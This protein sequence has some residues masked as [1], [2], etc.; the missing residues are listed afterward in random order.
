MTHTLRLDV[1]EALEERSYRTIQ[2]LAL[3]L[4]SGTPATQAQVR[5]VLFAEPETFYQMEDW[6]DLAIFH[7]FEGQTFHGRGRGGFDERKFLGRVLAE[8]LRTKGMPVELKTLAEKYLLKIG[9]RIGLQKSQFPSGSTEIVRRVR[10]FLDGNPNYHLLHDECIEC[11]WTTPEWPEVAEPA[12]VIA[13]AYRLPDDFLDRAAI[14]LEKRGA[15]AVRLLDILKALLGIDANHADF[16]AA[17]AQANAAL[18]AD[19][20]TFAQVQEQAWMLANYLPASIED[21]PARVAIPRWRNPQEEQLIAELY[22]LPLDALAEAASFAGDDARE[23]EPAQFDENYFGPLRL[24][25]PYHWRQ[26]G[27]LK[28]NANERRLFPDRPARVHLLFTDQTGE[29]FPVWLNNDTGYLHGLKEWYASYLVPAGGVFYIE[30]APGSHYNFK[31]RVKEAASR[32]FDGKQYFCEVDSDTYIEE[33][34]L[35][36]L[37]TLRAKVETAAATIKDVM[38][39]LFESG[40]PD[41]ALHYKQVWAQVHVIRPTTRRTVAAILSAFPCFYQDDPGSGCWRYVPGLR[42]APPKYQTRRVPKP[43]AAVKLAPVEARPARYWLAPVLAAS[44]DKL[45]RPAGSGEGVFLAPWHGRSRVGRG[46]G[47]AFFDTGTERVIAAVEALRQPILDAATGRRELTVKPALDAFN[48]IP[49]ANLA[50]ALSVPKPDPDGFPVEITPEDWKLLLERLRPL[51]VQKTIEPTL[52]ELVKKALPRPEGPDVVEIIPHTFGPNPTIGAFIA[53]YGRPYDPKEPYE[54]SAFATPVKAGKNTAIY[55]AHSYHTKVPPQ[56]IE[57]Y[58]EHY[59]RPGDIVLDPFCGSGMTGVASL[60]LG[61][62]VI[63]NDLSPAATHIAYNYCT[64]VDV[65]ALKREFERIKA[66]V[67]E[68]FDWLYGT[69]CNRCGG[70]AT[71]Q[72]T[73][74]SDVLECSKCGKEIILWKAAVDLDAGRV[75]EEFSCPNCGTKQTKRDTRWVRSDAVLTAYECSQCRPTRHEHTI[76]EA[77]GKRVDEIDLAAISYWYPTAP[78]DDSW[79]MW[80]GVHRDQGI[81]DVSRFYTKRNLWALARLWHEFGQ[82]ADVRIS[83][84]LRFVFTS[85]LVRAARM[86]RYNL[87][88]AGNAPVSGTLYVPSL[89]VE[90]NIL[91]LM[92]RKFDDVF[93]GLSAADWSSGTQAL[94][95]TGSATTLPKEMSNCVDYVFTDPPFGSNIFYADCNFIWEAW[96]SHGFTDQ[97]KEAVVHVKHRNKNTLPEYTQLMIDSFREMYRVLKP[98]RWA[99]VV[100]HNS[101]DRIWQAIQQAAEVAGFDLA[102]AMVFDKEQR[103]FKGI[104]GEK[105]LEKV[106]NFDIVLNLH[107]RGEAQPAAQPEAQTRIEELIAA[108][109][110]KHL[111]SSPAPDYRTGQYLH[112]LAIRTLLN[113]KISV[114]LTWNQLEG[115]L[116]REFRHVNCHWYLPREAVTATGHGFLVRSETAAVA[117]LE[118]ILAAD[119]QTAADL[120]PQWQIA[121]LGAGSRI[122]ATLDEL[123]RDNFWPDET[124]GAWTV[125]TPAQREL[126]RKR[127]PRPQQ[128]SLGLEV[129]GEQMGLG[130]R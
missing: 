113:E 126:L 65:A 31:V 47:L 91:K 78:F 101:D 89:S 107:K 102:N 23:S 61:R 71:I 117:W 3:H 12:P 52:E 32:T 16:S 75:S 11:V 62:R 10:R 73:I 90:N 115:I 85:A 48:P 95:T 79:E 20:E 92:D 124:T 13:P 59:T 97:R 100:F 112:S 123:L 27:V 110:Q 64:P 29:T 55:N 125:A 30:R 104:R 7:R 83:N 38:C 57:P 114:E 80:R 130:L 87:G 128:L 72:Y 106:T 14:Y 18:S 93:Q 122:K 26:N 129:E 5:A 25:L 63:L 9:A 98:G 120:I 6:W 1:Y 94:I 35:A 77:E 103:S 118:H 66:A 51:M 82:I 44:W 109:V 99:S 69:T 60:K 127:R 111:A 46:D 96:L 116:A 24:V 2:D 15:Q 45:T 53:K 50:G 40:P 49:Y 86:T 119:P 33:D 17:F 42:N 22:E 121:T 41:A 19:D 88:K 76:S 67:K 108:A 58:I 84:A 105:G 36:D 56:G 54:R 74:W 81:T 43:A 4:D 28:V 39:D 70:P 8:A 34:R 68:E 21:I 37:V